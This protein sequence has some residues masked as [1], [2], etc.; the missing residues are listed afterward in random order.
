MT[1]VLTAEQRL[2]GLATVGLARDEK[3]AYFWNGSGPIPSVTTIIGVVDKSGPLIG[4]AKRTTAEAAVDNAASIPGWVNLAG[5]DGAISLLT[6]AATVQR[7][8]AADAGTAVHAYAEAISRGQAIEVPEDY[9]PFVAV[10]RRWIADF[11]PHFLAAEE[12]VCSLKYH[13]AGTLD[14]ICTL[15]GETWLLDYKTAK[16]VYPETALQLAAYAHAEFIGRPGVA[17]KFAIPKIAQYGVLHLRPEGYELVPFSVSSD[18][19]KAFLAAKALYEWRQ[20]E[21]PVGIP[22]GPQIPALAK[23]KIA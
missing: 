15:A 21:S 14:A 19:F 2:T 1:H 23:E 7:D 13:Y 9:A 5:R 16:G 12:M 3:H 6:K 8:R 22:L 10:Y 11:S 20:A 4:W 17:R 18:T